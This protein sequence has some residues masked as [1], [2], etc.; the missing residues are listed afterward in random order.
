MTQKLLT[1]RALKALKPAPPG[2]RYE[3]MDAVTPG[4]GVRV[5][6]K[7]HRSFVLITRYPGSKSPARRALGEYGAISLEDARI[8]AREWIDLIKRG[9]DPKAEADRTQ[10]AEQRRQAASFESVVDAYSAYVKRQKLRSAGTVERSLRREFV[11]DWGTRPITDIARADV[12]EIIKA[13]A[14][15]D[16]RPAMAHNLLAY[17]RG[18]FNWAVEQGT[19]GMDAS[20]CDRIKPK[21]IIGRKVI[22]SR[23]LADAELRAYWMAADAAGHP[24]GTMFKLLAITGQRRTEVSDA[25]WREIDFENRLWTI[26][27]ARMKADSDHIVPLSKMAVSLLA[28]LPR[29]KEGDFVFSTTF[30]RVPVSGFS[31]AKSRLDT[32]MKK[33]TPIDRPFVIHDI[34]RTMR[35]GLS[36]LPI[37][38][39]VRELVIAHT[40][41]GL[42]KVY[43]QFA[44]LDEKRHAMDLWAAQLAKIVAKK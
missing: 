2:G 43:D 38:D 15:D 32:S 28:G 25:R 12:V 9:I 11:P 22:R 13:K 18:M 40:K 5:T 7:G 34:R 10:R 37:S 14:E 42:H 17:V 35:T 20:P 21:L 39:I 36:A 8:K 26:P 4:L 33:I 31:K 44:Y 30:G 6:D 16:G 27:A 1:D 24:F 23:V 3:I 41:Q 29:M 19:Y